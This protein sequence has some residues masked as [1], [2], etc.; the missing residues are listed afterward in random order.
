MLTGVRSNERYF[1]KI[2]WFFILFILFLGK[3]TFQ[4]LS[5]KI[6][7]SH[8]CRIQLVGAV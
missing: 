4:R 8:V 2:K 6:A 1:L 3:K 7:E 5:K